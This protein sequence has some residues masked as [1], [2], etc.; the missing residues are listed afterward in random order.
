MAIIKRTIF[1]EG[2]SSTGSTHGLL[3]ETTIDTNGDGPPRETGVRFVITG[4][5]GKRHAAVRLS[6]SDTT[7]VSKFLGEVVDG[8]EWK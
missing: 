7:D 1:R 3:I 8:S 5:N 4:A 6:F 2:P